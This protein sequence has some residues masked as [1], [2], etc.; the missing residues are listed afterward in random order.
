MKKKITINWIFW[1]S[2]YVPQAKKICFN[3]QWFSSSLICHKKNGIGYLELSIW[4]SLQR[5]EQL[6]I[7]Y[8]RKFVNIKKIQKLSGSNLSVSSSQISFWR[9][10]SNIRERIFWN[11][12][13]VLL[14]LFYFL[15]NI[16][17]RIVI[18]CVVI[19][20]LTQKKIKELIIRKFSTR[21]E[22]SAWP[23]N[24]KF[25]LG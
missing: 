18:F 17:S 15:T 10:Q 14:D 11:N 1:K 5:A 21:F 9:Q 16:L 7:Y 20:K 3:I 25:Q 23:T 13:E 6:K 19:R 2:S 22:L 12:P 4:V 8:I 24:L